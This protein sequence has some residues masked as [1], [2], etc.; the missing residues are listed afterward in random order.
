MKRKL[1][2]LL[3]ILLVPLV[4]VS[5][6][7]IIL[8]NFNYG[9]R[10]QPI[11]PAKKVYPDKFKSITNLR[12]IVNPRLYTRYIGKASGVGVLRKHLVSCPYDFFRNS[13]TKNTFRVFVLGGSSAAGKPFSHNVRWLEVLEKMLQDVL[14]DKEV[15]VINQPEGTL[16]TI[17]SISKKQ[18]II[19]GPN[20]SQETPNSQSGVPR[21]IQEKKTP[22]SAHSE[23]QGRMTPIQG[24]ISSL[25]KPN[26]R[27][28]YS[29]Q[30]KKVDVYYGPGFKIIHRGSAP[31]IGLVRLTDAGFGET[32]T[33]TKRHR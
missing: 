12:S 10:Y 25:K 6:S 29:H 4:F 21:A 15:E 9:L 23:K 18:Q 28:A 32:R 13:K 30:P 5:T 16:S 33:E 27:S 17:G 3:T 8:R 19:E 20:H 26:Q 31:R 24:T 11:I 2:Y 14:P 1:A 22:Q 7:E